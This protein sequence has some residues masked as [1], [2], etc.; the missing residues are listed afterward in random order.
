MKKILLLSLVFIHTIVYCQKKTL[1]T[2]FITENITID[3]KLDESVWNSAEIAKDFIMFSPD[4]GKII[5][6]N[7][8]TEVKVL[9]DNH[10]IY[11]AALLYD[12]EPK[13]ILKE[14]SQR[15]E[16][17]GI[18]DRFGVYINGNNDGQQDYRFYITASDGQSDCLATDINGEDYTWDAVWQSKAVITDSGWAVEIKIPYAAIR[19]SSDKKQSWGINFIRNIRR[20]RQNYT[21]NFID[22]KIE[23]L[24]QQNGVLEGLENIETPTRLFF[25]PYSSYYLNANSTH[26]TKGILKGGLDI[27]YGINDAFTLD[28]IL[29]PDFGQTKFDDQIL[30]LGPFEQQFTENRAF[31]TEGTDLFSKGG[32]FYSRRIGG[33][34]LYK[35]GENEIF[36]ESSSISLINAIKISGRTKSGLGIGVLNAITEK[37]TVNI[38]DLKNGEI[39][40][41]IEPL[42]N[43]NVLV[44]DQRFHKNSSVSFVNTNLTRNSRFRD[45]NVSALVWN[46]NTAKNT[47]N[48]SGDIKYSYVNDIQ[49]KKGLFSELNFAETSGKYRYKFG[50]DITTKDYQINDLGLNYETNNYSFNAATNYRILNPTKFFNFF[51]TELK[52]YTQFQ[53]ETGKLQSNNFLI[54]TQLTNKKNHYFGLQLKI[55]PIKIY[56]FYE[57]RTENRYVIIPS[58]VLSTFSFSSNYNYKFA[59]D[60]FP[61]FT[62][63]NETGRNTFDLV[64]A[65]RY[66]FSDKILLKYEFDYNQQNNTKGYVDGKNTPEIIFARRDRT[67][68]VNTISTKYSL[69]P[70]MTFN[71][72]VRHYWSFA[73]NKQF[74]TL[75]NDG[76]FSDNT[77]YLQNKNSNFNAWNLDLAYSWQFAPGSQMSILYRNNSTNF[78]R[79]IDKNLGNNINHLLN[80]D[81]LSHVLSISVKYFID[82][83]QAKHWF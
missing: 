72:S 29:I 38:L 42:S 16:S 31:F 46:L 70:K 55:S 3:G 83:N 11:I 75:Q 8:K 2:K 71:L 74:F 1:Q 14:I 62:K 78:S 63:F 60:F 66:R 68:Y 35:L 67:T 13:K 21:W 6:E 7:K 61:T 5:P 44:L 65:P 24:T 39:R 10:A 37:T 76:N 22:A 28:A 79:D 59:L 48:L 51:T 54:F 64:L 52:Y 58:Y 33:E 69:S 73:N 4:N 30:N 47:Y 17:N 80:N 20:D 25:L 57:P 23:S 45:A 26:K 12:D 56:D 27:K 53:K 43:Y 77:S 9:Y 32:L 50:A 81:A 41:E 40:S 18:S 36:A 82:Y 34:P 15:D 19:F 49:D